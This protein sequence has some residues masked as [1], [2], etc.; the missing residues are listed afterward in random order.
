M[1]YNQLYGIILVFISKNNRFPCQKQW[2][3]IEF[4]D[5][6]FFEIID[7]NSNIIDFVV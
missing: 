6:F 5:L 1:E 4:N 7:N 2:I 3:T